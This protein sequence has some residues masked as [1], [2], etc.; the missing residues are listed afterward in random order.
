MNRQDYIQECQKQLSNKTFYQ[1]L[2]E[3][4]NTDYISDVRRLAD[5]MKEGDMISDN[6]HKFLTQ[7]LDN[8]DTPIF[9]ILRSPKDPQAV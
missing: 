2:D 4:P 8:A 1:K 9:D 7:H 6:E 3:D 5:D